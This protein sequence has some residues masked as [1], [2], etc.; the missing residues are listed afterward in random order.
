MRSRHRHFQFKHAGAVLS[1]DARFVH[2]VSDAANLETWPDRSGGGKNGTRTLSSIPTYRSTEINGTPAIRFDNQYYDVTIS[3]PLRST[4]IAVLRRQTAGTRSTPLA[5][6]TNNLPYSFF[7]FSDNNVYSHHTTSSNLIN[8]TQQTEVGNFVWGGIWDDR[9][10]TV[11]RNGAIVGSTQTSASSP[12]GTFTA[13][14]R[15][16]NSN[17]NPVSWG[18]YHFLNIAASS[19]LHKRLQHHVAFSFKITCN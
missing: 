2:G 8:A 17:A 19:S 10:S 15:F 13:L 3:I 9:S 5:S 4:T 6:A 12:S 1:L 14:G 7:W 18:A 11:Y 16:N